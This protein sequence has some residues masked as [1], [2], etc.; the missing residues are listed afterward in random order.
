MDAFLKEEVEF[1][2]PDNVRSWK[3]SSKIQVQGNMA[4]KTTIRTLKLKDGKE[5][6]LEKTMEKKFEL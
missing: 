5:E 3:Q 4:K 2:M 6:T 1:D